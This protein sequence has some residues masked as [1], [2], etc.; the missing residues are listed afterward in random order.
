M[1]GQVGGAQAALFIEHRAHQIGSAQNALHQEIGLALGTKC[2]GLGRAILIGIAGDDLVS[3]GV[4]TQLGQH[5]ADLLHMA[6]QNGRG[7]PLLAGFYHRFDDRLIVG[8]GHGN[9]TGSAL[10]GGLQNAINCTNHKKY[11]SSVY[12]CEN[13]QFLLLIDSIIQ[14]NNQIVNK[15]GE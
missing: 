4:F 5:G 14:R 11:A 12:F 1:G 3:G 9:H 8:G 2:H 13:A 15:I 7:D 10:L 6:H